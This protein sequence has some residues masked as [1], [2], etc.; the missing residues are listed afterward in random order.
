M[1]SRDCALG[2]CNAFQDAKEAEGA[3]TYRGKIRLIAYRDPDI[4]AGA[5]DEA[6][7]MSMAR[8]CPPFLGVARQ[9]PPPVALYLWEST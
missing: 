6:D 3:V 2:G 9:P 7:L 4:L 5:K 8:T 1:F